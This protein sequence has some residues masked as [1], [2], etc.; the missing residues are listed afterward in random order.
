MKILN[1]NFN[2]VARGF[3]PGILDQDDLKNK[4][5]HD[6]LAE[7]KTIKKRIYDDLC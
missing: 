4:F 3:F 5:D 2:K 7:F 6:S 1:E